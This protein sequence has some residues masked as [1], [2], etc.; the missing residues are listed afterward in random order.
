MFFISASFAD[1]AGIFW[2][3]NNFNI[4]LSWNYLESFRAV[5]PYF[6]KFST[7]CTMLLF[8]RNIKIYFTSRKVFLK[9]FT[10]ALSPFITF[11]EFFFE[12]PLTRYTCFN[13]FFRW[14]ECFIFKI[15]KIRLIIRFFCSGTETVT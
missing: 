15:K 1:S 2:T 7:A 3:Y 10:A 13:F 5:F 9:L 11:Y 4:N 6:Y 14:N 12:R 8:F